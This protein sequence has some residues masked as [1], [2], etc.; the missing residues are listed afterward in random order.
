MRAGETRRGL[1]KEGKL[2]YDA[3]REKNST[4]KRSVV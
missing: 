3:E 1:D 2:W 4:V